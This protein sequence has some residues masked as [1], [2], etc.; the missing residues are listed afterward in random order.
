MTLGFCVASRVATYLRAARMVRVAA[1]LVLV[2]ATASAEPAAVE[3]ERAERLFDEGRA[4]MAEEH[5]DVACAAFAESQKLDPAAGTLVNWGVCL[6]AQGKTASALAAYWA[7][8]ASGALGT[9]RERER[10][11]RERVDALAPTLSRVTIAVP[12]DSPAGMQVKL[13]GTAL[14]PSRWN[15]PAPADPGAHLLEVR[16]P[17]YALWSGTFT[18]GSDG[19]PRVV[20]VPPLTSVPA[21]R[22]S[23]A[24]EQPP[25]ASRRVAASPNRV[26]LAVAGGMAGLGVVGA[27]YFGVRAATAWGER[28]GHCPAERCDAVAVREWH[29]ATELAHAADVGIAV[30]V[31]ALGVGV[32]LILSPTSATSTPR[33]SVELGGERDGALLRWRRDF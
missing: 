14:D 15:T 28:Q 10:F 13:D 24:R 32:Y 22:P 8:L 23:A 9:D 18:V 21:P 27:A 6:E 4:A 19:S 1:G 26:A 7:S 11:V 16:A 29:R 2:A 31:A 20:Q 25:P 3:S 33:S 12:E 30:T 17:G 5:F